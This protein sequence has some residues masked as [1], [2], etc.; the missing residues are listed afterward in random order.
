MVTLMLAPNIY[1]V[2]HYYTITEHQVI[3][4]VC[5]KHLP[6]E[7]TQEQEQWERTMYMYQFVIKSPSPFPYEEYQLSEEIIMAIIWEL[8]ITPINISTYEASIDATRTDDTDPDNP[9]VYNVARAKIETPAQQVAVA[10][11]IWEKHQVALASNAAV[12][13]FV[14]V[15]E[16]A[17]KSNLEARE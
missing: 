9:M 17:G 11:E 5:E 12:E 14:S 4:Q 16:A 13:A 8:E 2:F 6:W 3:F 7:Y 15:L 10:D 1:S